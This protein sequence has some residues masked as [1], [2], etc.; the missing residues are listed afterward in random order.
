MFVSERINLE[1][2]LTVMKEQIQEIRENWNQDAIKTNLI[3]M[4]GN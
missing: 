2:K 3:L 4:D 1:S